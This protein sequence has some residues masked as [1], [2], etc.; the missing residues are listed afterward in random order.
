MT[1]KEGGE[2]SRGRQIATLGA[3]MIASS[4]ILAMFGVKGATMH[5]VL[6]FGG[7]GIGL[8]GIVMWRVLK[9]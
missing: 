4:L 5:S 2:A 3:L 1:D 6:E 9:K 7:I 8:V